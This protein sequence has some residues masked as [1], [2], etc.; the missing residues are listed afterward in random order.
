MISIDWPSGVIF[1][2]K[3]DLTLIQLVPTEIR[4][5]NLDQFHLWLKD[6][7]DSEDGI[8]FPDTHIH[9]TE[10]I[11][12][13]IVYARVIAMTNGY[14]VTFEDGAYAVNLVGAN[15]N[16]GDVVNVNNVSVR[17]QNSAGLISAQ[18][19]EYSSFDDCVTIDATS[20]NTGTTFPTGTKQKPVN[21][22]ADAL[23][24]AAV[25]GMTRL[26][27]IGDFTFAPGIMIS[28][29]TLEG[30][31]MQRSTLTFQAGS[32]AAYCFVKNCMATGDIL[33]VIGFEG[34]HISN[35][36]ST[37]P[38]PSSQTIIAKGCLIDG[39]LALPAL[40]SGTLKVLDCW[41]NTP[42]AAMPVLDMGGSHAN[43]L[44]RNYSGDIEFQNCTQATNYAEMD[45]VS[46]HLT[47]DS[48]VT[49]GTFVL[50][51]VATL[52]NNSTGTTVDTD[53]MISKQTIALAVESQIGAEIEYGAFQGRVWLDV[54]HG[55]DGTAYPIGTA[56][57]P[58]KN[59]IDARTI[60]I[61]RGFDRIHLLSDLTVASG[62][63]IDE[64]TLESDNWLSITVE[65]GASTVN[66]VFEKLSVYGV[67]GGFWNVLIDCWTYDITNFCGWLRGGSFVSVAL[68]PYTVE[69]AGQS[70]FDSILPMYPGTPS[71]LTMNT[72]TAVSFTN[73]I[74]VYQI[75]SMTDGS[76]VGFDLSGGTLTVDS[77]CIGGS[78]EVVGIGL[79]VNNSTGVSINSE[80]LLNQ[81][82][83]TG[84]I[85]DT[86]RGSH[87][88]P[89]SFGATEE[90]AGGGNPLDEVM[91]DHI[92][93]GTAGEAIY[94]AKQLQAGR[95]KSL[96]STMQHYAD[97]NTTVVKSFD[98]LNASGTPAALAEDV[99]ERVPH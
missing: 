60:S 46:G 18:A 75:N 71:V 51:G 52:I 24:I 17:S 58:V 20:S 47:L 15:S 99:V 25:R 81:G 97:N 66:T 95:A 16:V 13:G 39:T 90:W 33:G 36:N 78:I 70:F 6:M 26:F 74:D 72:D 31:G 96:G 7:E 43:I 85:W 53:G 37:S 14:T 57:A 59:I 92:T 35:M 21:N 93:P 67:M 45:F 56:A 80:G 86:S 50:R 27:F 42:G 30:E 84:S 9:N 19:I 4:E 29:M 62:E 38:I 94:L 8:C 32:V 79:L 28:G 2:P 12:G 11:L 76:L 54:V 10:V 22:L 98:L 49:A 61:A 63:V 23:L 44:V 64:L 83:L 48:S 73:A 87:D 89:G 55:T 77:S 40:Y 34:C 65:D 88:V 91:E 68:A 3:A 41:S 82:D 5:L 1:V 69:S